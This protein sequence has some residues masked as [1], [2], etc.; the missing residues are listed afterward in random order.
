MRILNYGAG[1]VGLGIDSC[2]IKTGCHLDI[3]A[4][5]ETVKALTAAGLKRKG[6]LGSVQWSPERFRAYPSLDGLPPGAYDVILVSTKSFDSAEAARDLHNHP[7]LFHPGTAIVLF[8]NGWGN[9]EHFTAYFNAARIF[10]ARV[11]T[12]FVRQQ[13]NVVDITVHADAIHIGC[14]AGGDTLSIEP[15]CRKISEGGIPAQTT[16]AIA[17]DLWAKMLYNCALNPLGAILNV[18]YGELG[19][20]SLSRELCDAIITEVFQVMVATGHE[21]HWRTSEDYRDIFYATLLPLTASHHSSTW[22][23]LKSGKKTEI[24]ALNGIVIQLARRHNIPVPVNHVVYRMIKFLER[25]L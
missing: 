4:R 16:D 20:S 11:I 3:L 6:I 1:A 18:T 22:Q 10:N 21:T 19:Q 8:Q 24:D 9:T 2:L 15:L 23:D 17:K 7:E 25:G 5:P 14:L 13:P 12:G